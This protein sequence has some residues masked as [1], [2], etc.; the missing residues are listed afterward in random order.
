MAAANGGARC[1]L[2]FM[3]PNLQKV[4]PYFVS[5]DSGNACYVCILYLSI[6]APY[7]SHMTP[8]S[9]Q[10][11][12]KK[13]RYLLVIIRF[14]VKIFFNLSLLSFFGYFV[15]VI[16]IFVLY[17]KFKKVQKLYWNKIWKHLMR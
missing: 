2:D 1:K 10:H 5:W 13:W 4:I 14:L 17:N 8:A 12:A 7:A 16:I 9:L 6:V 15:F 3:A 11:L